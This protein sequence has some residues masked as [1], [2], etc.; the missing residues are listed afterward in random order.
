M[1]TTFVGN[2][3]PSFDLPCTRQPDPTRGRARLLDYKGRWLV[4]V[5]YPRDFSM[6][7]PTELIGLSQ[8][9]EEFAEHDCDLLAISCDPVE[10]HE[11]WLATP[12]TQGGLGGLSFPLASDLDGSVSAAYG[13]FEP[14][15]NLAV[16]GTFIVDPDGRIQYQVVHSLSV[17]R[18]SQEV[19]RVLSALQSGGLCREDWMTDGS[20]I[21]PYTVLQPGNIFSHYYM[22]SEIGA[23]T[24]ARV[25][26]ARDL[27]LD[28]PVALKVFNRDCPVTPSS[29]LAEARSVAALNHPNICT[30]YAV[31]DTAGLPVIAMEYVQGL[32]LANR[33]RGEPAAIDELL[34]IAR[35]IAGGMAAAHDAGIVHGDLKPENIMVGDDG[36]V[37]VLDFGLARRINRVNATELEETSE[38]GLAEGGDGVFGT[39]RYL[40]P[41]QTRGEPATFASDVF[42]LGVVFFEM[43]TRRPAFAEGNVLQVMD[44]IR[45]VDPEA[46]AAEAGE[47][48][49]PLLRSMLLADPTRRDVAMRRIV[50]EIDAVCESV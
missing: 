6:V 41:E 7:C 45:N 46:M 3:A 27:Q 48:F 32:S 4:L 39:P 16:R 40:A 1:P 29:V 15:Q 50:A 9:R 12:K 8:R 2:P 38:L 10:L 26:L 44:R 36:L 35:Q 5:F 43:A 31:D 33:L 47:P 11:R 13:V 30:I 18:R 24:F 22:D 20:H 19:L 49:T 37:K 17:G 23:G 25:Y 14:R 42:A 21:D 28:R 34:A